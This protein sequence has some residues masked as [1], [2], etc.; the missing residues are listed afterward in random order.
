[1]KKFVS[2]IISICVLLTLVGCIG[3]TSR[4]DEKVSKWEII[5]VS[6]SPIYKQ[7]N[8]G[9]AEYL[10]VTVMAEVV[11]ANAE[12]TAYEEV[13]EQWIMFTIENSQ[14]W[15]KE[16]TT[17]MRYLEDEFKAKCEENKDVIRNVAITIHPAELIDVLI[18]G[19][20]NTANDTTDIVYK[21][22]VKVVDTKGIDIYV[23]L[24]RPVIIEMTK[25][26]LPE[27]FKD[28]ES[29]GIWKYEVQVNI[30]NVLKENGVEL[31][32]IHFDKLVLEE[33]GMIYRLYI[34]DYRPL[35]ED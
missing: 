14:K 7:Y 10:T 6:V 13:I 23:K 9:N 19:R 24:V 16:V 33:D 22:T 11:C 12:R 1:M 25:T 2:I 3:C 5:D 28:T 32:E 29:F 27:T 18:L 20:A 21:G 35:I 4:P 26:M 17:R 31:V 8:N 34:N 30:N 15:S